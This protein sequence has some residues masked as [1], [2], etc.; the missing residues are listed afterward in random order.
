MIGP[1]NHSKE[2][3]MSR[4]RKADQ[5][6]PETPSPAEAGTAVAEPPAPEAGTPV[7]EPPVD[8]PKTDGQG[9]ADKVGQKKYVPA[10]DPFGIAK[11]N[12]AG[13]RL[14]QSNEDRQMAI[15]F[16]EGRPEDKPSQ[17]VIDKMKEA[18]Y[19]WNNTH[20]IW[21][22][23]VRRDSAMSTRIDAEKLYQEVRH[24]IRAEMGIP[25]EPTQGVPF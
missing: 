11:D 16:G 23:P 14:F 18:G 6:S 13:V 1:H 8:E 19:R 10:P 7:I 9:F 5:Q 24:M 3:T 20:K 4:K 17:A 22:N 2:D 21:A 12:L 25:A 15:Q